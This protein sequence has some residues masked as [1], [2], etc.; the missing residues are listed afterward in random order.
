MKKL[1]YAILVFIFSSQFLQAQPGCPNVTVAPTNP[2]CNGSCTTLS[3]TLQG[4][5]ATTSYTVDSIPYTPFS[6]NTG[7]PILIG[8]DDQ[9]SDTIQLPFCFDFFGTT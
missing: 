9:W 8:I 4:T 3:A 2:I 6:Y 1:L 5:V 7:V